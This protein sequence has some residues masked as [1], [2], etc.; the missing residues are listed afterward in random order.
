MR[1]LLGKLETNT[2]RNTVISPNFLLWKFCEKAQFLHSFGWFVQNYTE[3]V[4]FHKTSARG[5]LGEITGGYFLQW[6]LMTVIVPSF[7]RTSLL[8]TQ[9]EIPRRCQSL[10]VPQTFEIDFLKQ[11]EISLNWHSKKTASESLFNI[12]LVQ[13]FPIYKVF[14]VIQNFLPKF[15]FLS[16]LP[17]RFSKMASLYYFKT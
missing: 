3:T 7:F 9:M 6:N 4:P 14:V 10:L 12:T 2:T 13:N 17:L 1:I 5:K 16:N 11:S 8:W 15:C